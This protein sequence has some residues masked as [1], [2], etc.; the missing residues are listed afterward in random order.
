M[1]LRHVFEC[2]NNHIH[3]LGMS[4]TRK[5]EKVASLRFKMQDSRCKI[6]WY[7]NFSFFIFNFEFVHVYWRIEHNRIIST[8]PLPHPFLV[9][10]RIDE[11]HIHL[12]NL[13]DIEFSKKIRRNHIRNPSI[14]GHF[15]EIL[16]IEVEEVS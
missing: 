9:S 7:R 12:A 6:I 2:L 11:N 15:R 5:G 13:C 4:E 14:P 1:F 3:S 10:Q 16:I 8:K